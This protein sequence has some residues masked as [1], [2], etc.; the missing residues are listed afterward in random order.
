MLFK[1][2]IIC[3]VHAFIFFPPRK[4]AKTGRIDGSSTRLPPSGERD[5][6]RPKSAHEKDECPSALERHVTVINYFICDHVF[7][8]TIPNLLGIHNLVPRPRYLSPFL[9]Q[10]SNSWKNLSFFF[11]WSYITVDFH[12]SWNPGRWTLK[13]SGKVEFSPYLTVYVQITLF[14]NGGSW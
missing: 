10:P 1:P 5:R 4:Q 2:E 13:W 8:L 7:N 11:F 14:N 12:G 9:P 6:H 3:L